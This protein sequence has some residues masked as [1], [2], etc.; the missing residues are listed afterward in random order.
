MTQS[1]NSNAQSSQSLAL[2]R[3]ALT[4]PY[5]P[6]TSKSKEG[7]GALEFELSTIENAPPT[8]DQIRTLLTY[9]KLPLSSLL[10]AHPA[11]GTSPADSAESL[12]QAATSNPKI[13]RFPVIV[14]WDDGDAALDAGGVKKMLDKL[15]ERRDKGASSGSGK[16]SSWF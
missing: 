12:A 15:A 11:S 8:A 2:L 3:S 7:P 6:A 13:F 5:P 10:S 1:H 16:S 9:L 4:S 14:N